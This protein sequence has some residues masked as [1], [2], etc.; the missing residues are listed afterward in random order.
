MAKARSR[1]EKFMIDA[2]AGMISEVWLSLR[3]AVT[4]HGGKEADIYI[5]NTP[6][7]KSILARLAEMI[8]AKAAE[9]LLQV[10]WSLVLPWIIAACRFVSFVHP[11]ITAE[12]FPLLPDDLRIKEVKVV[13]AGRTMSTPEVLKWLDKQGLRPATFLELLFWWLT[14]QDVHKDCLVV[15]LGQVWNGL[16]A[17]VN[18]NGGS[19]QL[20][21]RG[22]ADGWYGNDSFAAV[23]KWVKKAA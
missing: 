16:V 1:E 2:A 15:A 21:L 5:L 8:V 17:Y 6:E 12:R 20:G 14:N 11:D 9:P 23:E 13:E 7:G 18:G 4:D 10:S 22:V 19:R 3:R